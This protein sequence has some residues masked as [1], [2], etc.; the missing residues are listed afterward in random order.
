MRYGNKHSALL[1][2]KKWLQT[3]THYT[4]T[5]NIQLDARSSNG[6]L[7]NEV[8]LERFKQGLIKWVLKNIPIKSVQQK[9]QMFGERCRPRDMMTP[10]A[11]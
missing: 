7:E 9:F 11:W 10:R 8:K 1:Y 5:Q 4:H 6:N 3:H 2:F